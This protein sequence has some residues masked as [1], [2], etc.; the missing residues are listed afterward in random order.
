MEG[1]SAGAKTAKGKRGGR[2]ETMSMR[3]VGSVTGATGEERNDRAFCSYIAFATFCS[4]GTRGLVL[5]SGGV[6]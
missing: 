6:H 1:T 3:E 2:E 5:V 4:H